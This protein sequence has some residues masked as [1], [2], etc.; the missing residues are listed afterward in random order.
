M[1][2]IHSLPPTHPHQRQPS[3]PR[4][5]R[6]SIN[7][8]APRLLWCTYVTMWRVRK[9]GRPLCVRCQMCVRVVVGRTLIPAHTIILYSILRSPPPPSR[10]VKKNRNTPLVW[11]PWKTPVNPAAEAECTTGQIIIIVWRRRRRRIT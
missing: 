6:W 5:Q 4:D 10:R 2:T 9:I 3:R 7:R 1:I 8:R 11:R